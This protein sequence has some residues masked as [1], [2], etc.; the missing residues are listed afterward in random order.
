M[1]QRYDEFASWY[2]IYVTSGVGQPYARSADRL[3]ARLL[4]PGHDRPCLDLGCGGGAHV[5]PL[6]ST[7]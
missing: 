2:D 7:R 5:R 3:L 1:G 6:C 4:G